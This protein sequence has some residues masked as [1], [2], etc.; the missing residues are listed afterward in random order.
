[1]KRIF[2]L[3]IVASFALSGCGASQTEPSPVSSISESSAQESPHD[4]SSS[5]VESSLDS[6]SS[7]E[8]DEPVGIKGSHITD[9]MLGLEQTGAKIPK[10]EL[11]ASTDKT[12]SA[13]YCSA[14][15]DDTDVGIVFDYSLSA[16]NAMALISGTFSATTSY[17]IDESTFVEVAKSYLGFCSTMPCDA[18]TDGIARLWL[19]DTFDHL[20]ERNSGT[21]IIFDDAKYQLE[22]SKDESGQITS[23]WMTISRVDPE[24]TATVNESSESFHYVNP[25]KN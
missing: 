4:V 19:E 14:M 12:V 22:W 23:I 25:P 7:H 13:H 5:V 3:L 21:N 16:D 6:S 10:P 15:K 9:I 11:K 17:L 24:A 20:S 18:V 8:A 1:M 2:V